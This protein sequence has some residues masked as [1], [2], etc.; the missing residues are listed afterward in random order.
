MY[1]QGWIKDNTLV[2][3]NAIID[4]SNF[5]SNSKAYCSEQTFH[6]YK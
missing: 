4:G 6:G 3:N 5:L 1:I 2:W